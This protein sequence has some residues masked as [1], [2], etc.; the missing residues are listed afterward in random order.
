MFNNLISVYKVFGPVK[1]FNN[2]YNYII[3]V[4]QF[5]SKIY[6]RSL[7]CHDKN[8]YVISIISKIFISP[9]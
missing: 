2:Y 4:A 9:E 7:K 6:R 1:C 3:C 8:S 5:V